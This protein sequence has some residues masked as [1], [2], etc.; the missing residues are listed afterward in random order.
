MVC[1]FLVLSLLALLS[2]GNGGSAPAAEAYAWRPVVIRGGGYVTG[3]EFHPREPDLLYAR[4]DVGGAYRWDA[5]RRAW[6]PLNDG[7]DRAHND[8]YA[9][10]SLAPDPRDPDKV[11]LAC[12]AYF[13]DWA[14]K[15]AVLR[16]ADRGRT[17]EGV[18]LPFKL[19]GNQ[20]GRGMGERLRVD[21]HDGD[22]LL[23]GT[24]RDGLW[25]SRD[26]GRSW[27]PVKAWPAR[28]VTFVLFDPASGA[29]GKPTPV[30]YAGAEGAEG[31]AVY[32]STDAGHSW[33]PVP[34]AP[35]GLL[36]HQ[37]ALDAGGT[38]Y[39]VFG[40]KPGPN[41]V[42]DGAV[43]K[44]EP[45]AGHWTDIT[46]ARPKPAERD[47]FGYAGLG[48]DARQPG[49]VFVSTLDRWTKRDE[50]FRTTD[51]GATWTPLLAHS[52]WD[53]AGAPY[54]KALKPHWISDVAL[55]PFHP[56]RLWFVTGYGVWATDRAQAD[57]A[58]GERVGWVFP[59]Q[60]LEETVIDE[61]VSPPA[62]APLL[63]V[64]GDL[65]GF[66]HDDLAVSPAAG[67]MQPFHGS[68]PGIAFAEL[69]PARMVRTHYGPARGAISGDGG[70]TWKNFATAPK[71][72]TEHGPGLAAIS[73]DGARLVWLP[74]GG[75]PHWS[76][77]DGATWTES[78]TDL[79]ATTEWTTYGPVA[80]RVNPKR[81]TIYDPLAGLLHV[82]ED[83]GASF[84][85]VKKVPVDGGKLRAEPGV[86]DRL[87]LPT[88]QGLLVLTNGGRDSAKIAGVDAANQ[89]GFGA[90]MP[91]RTGPAI[92]LDGTVRGEGA[93]FRSDDG[94]KTWV[95]I[96]DGQMRLGWLRCLTG[97]PR[98]P[99]RVYLGTSGR[100]I[101]RG[102]PVATQK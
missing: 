98:V 18:D 23:L 101:L 12:G 100:G 58:A 43:W 44:Y 15:A 14:R 77:D 47:T 41:D 89:V 56:E 16:S 21:P 95:R 27:H 13:A 91:G 66:R 8:L 80:D 63:S 30:I 45:A 53:P 87:W 2:A 4:T 3:L 20:D 9:V 73:P 36:A 60:G 70:A 42:T 86:A 75:K 94:G 71:A 29:D 61:L 51:G 97:D 102:E 17:W 90:P 62:G 50:I 54:V 88:S 69:A 64:M 65:G 25:R 46:P 84:T 55:D 81:F 83:G 22:E 35:A 59:D 52:D 5:G 93:F 37:A 31:A 68:S 48:V 11:Y 49:R 28:G 19:G 74:K 7:L 39:G 1:R 34:G 6:Q 78:A 33:Q 96:S 38:L 57:V 40:N 92:F 67:M 32:R 85:R 72:A 26:A 24:N 10:L 99:G 76:A 82:S 79:V